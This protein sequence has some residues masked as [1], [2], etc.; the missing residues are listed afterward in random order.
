MMKV[1]E[2]QLQ[3]KLGGK[4]YSSYTAGIQAEVGEAEDTAE[5]YATIRSICLNEARKTREQ[6]EEGK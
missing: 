3:V 1:K 2:I 6:S 5:A 4:N